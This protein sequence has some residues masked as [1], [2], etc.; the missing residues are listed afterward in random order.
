MWR[1]FEFAGVDGEP[2][3]L[4]RFLGQ[5]NVVLVI[6]RGNTSGTGSGPLY[7]NICLYCATQTSRLMA[8]YPAIRDQNAEVVVVFPVRK[9]TDS[10]SVGEFHEAL[11][12]VGKTSEMPFPL[13]LDVE[14]TRR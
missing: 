5:S 14:L 8:N 12:T 6:T 9:P 11:Q 10:G 3:D 4:T 1:I 13:L 2:A 7:G